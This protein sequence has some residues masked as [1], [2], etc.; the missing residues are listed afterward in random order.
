MTTTF[1]TNHTPKGPVTVLGQAFVGETL[2]ARPNGIGDEDGIDY[3]TATYQWLRDGEIITGATAQTYVVGSSDVGSHL[4]VRYTYVDFG[5]T[6]EILISDPE[7]AVPPEGTPIDQDTGPYNPLIVLGDPEVGENLTARPNAVMD[8]NGIDQATVSFQWLRDGEPIPGATSQ[9]YTVT[10]ADI[11]ARISV[12]YA[13]ADLLGEA[14]TLVSNPKLPVPEPIDVI[15]PEPP[16]DDTPDDLLEGTSG[17]DTLKA[18]AGLKRINGLDE[19]DTVLFEGDQSD[20]TVIFSPTSV[21]VADHRIGGLG[22]ILL[23]NVELID[24]GAAAEGF[25]GPI[26][27]DALT[28]LASLD[29]QDV[30]AIIELYIAYFDRAPDALGL[31]FWGTSFANGISL[32]EMAALFA[33]QE[34]TRTLYSDAASNEQFASSVYMN[35]LGRQADQDGLEFW[36]NALDSG[37]VSRDA[38]ILNVLNGAR[39]AL[40]I[41]KGHSFVQQQLADRFYLD[42]KVD[43]GAVFAVH[44]GLS[45]VD[46]AA[47]VM[48]IY[49]GS[50]QS[51]TAAVDLIDDFYQD[52]MNPFDGEFLLQVIG[53]MDNPFFA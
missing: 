22:T 20:Y 44:R 1:G 16:V 33:D 11:D 47:S 3:S 30:E 39:S 52:A 8:D 19:T 50:S 9:I 14:K 18:A 41:E 43:L 37:N 4:S 26:A 5:G 51:V 46:N 10:D 15:T 38:F 2:I 48:D 45:D 24:F 27:L 36:T 12:Q 29:R 34:E 32:Q 17:A 13:Y 42:T 6:L 49:D 31:N 35:V 25:D 53:V 23:D 40:Q 28:G 21:S 7:P